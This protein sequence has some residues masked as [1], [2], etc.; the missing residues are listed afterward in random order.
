MID[1][2]AGNFKNAGAKGLTVKTVTHTVRTVYSSVEVKP[3]MTRTRAAKN[4]KM[5]RPRKKEDIVYVSRGVSINP[6]L[7]EAVNEA[8]S[9]GYIAGVTNFSEAV[10]KALTRLISFK[11]KKKASA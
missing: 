3:T 6:E 1:I 10:E 11:P 9:N 4:P 8:V 5:G 2:P 7:L